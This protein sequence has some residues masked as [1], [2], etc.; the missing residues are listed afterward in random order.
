MEDLYREIILDHYE[1]PRNY[2][3]L[4]DADIS[5]EDDNPLCGDRIRIDL[6][7][8]D[9]RIVDVRFSGKGC[10]ISQ[11]SA[12]MLT[13]RIKGA[14]V[15]EARRLTRDDI[16]EMLGIPLG[17]ARIK[18]ALLSLKVLKAGLYGLPKIDWDELG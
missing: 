9:G 13:E 16:L 4:P 2:G 15:E 3:V 1:N 18:C 12:S 7:V 6:K 14:T 8:Q 10:A 17:P 11:A 5:Y